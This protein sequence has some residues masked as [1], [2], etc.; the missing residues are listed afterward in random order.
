MGFPQESL[1][2]MHFR[3]ARKLRRDLSAMQLGVAVFADVD[4]LVTQ[5]LEF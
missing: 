1:L 5:N 4:K 3:T 2:A